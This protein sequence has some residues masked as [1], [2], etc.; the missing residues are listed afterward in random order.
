MSTDTVLVSTIGSLPFYDIKIKR[1]ITCKL[2]GQKKVAS[3][4][5]MLDMR[6]EDHLFCGV[7]FRASDLRD[8]DRGEYVEVKTKEEQIKLV[9][10]MIN[11]LHPFKVTLPDVVE[12][13]KEQNNNESEYSV[14]GAISE[15]EDSVIKEVHLFSRYLHVVHAVSVLAV[16]CK[17]GDLVPTNK[18][19][20]SGFIFAS[21]ATVLLYNSLMSLFEM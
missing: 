17:K 6:L 8:Y 3:F 20:K 4:D 13:W 21:P 5:V 10:R 1:E 11:T 7:S 2:T 9:D 15:L 14:V 16:A 12:L 19:Y 18:E